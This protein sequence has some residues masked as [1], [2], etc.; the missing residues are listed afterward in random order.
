MVYGECEARAGEEAGA[1]AACQKLIRICRRCEIEFERG[2]SRETCHACGESRKCQKAAVPG[3]RWCTNHGGPVPARNFYG[4]GG[5]IVTGKNSQFQLT[6]LAAKY[7]EVGANGQILSNRKAMEIIG[8]RIQ[9]L[10]E[11]IDLS[12]APERVKML[13]MLWQEYKR[14]LDDGRDMEAIQVR[15][16]IDD[17]FE[18][19]YHEYAAW[20]QMFDALDLNRKMVDSEV[21]ILKEIKA[22]ITAE[23]AMEL[24]A[25]LQAAVMRV[26]DDPKKIRQIEYEFNRLIGGVSDNAAADDEEIIEG[27]VQED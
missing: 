3:Y 24:V 16:K 27:S 26:E 8:V 23:D 7:N 6:R 1:V 10:A 14:M 2:D 22:I 15:N 13:Y 25:K 5:P 18:K 9:Q 20:S 12:E 4:K 21:K 11:K 19:V 17:E